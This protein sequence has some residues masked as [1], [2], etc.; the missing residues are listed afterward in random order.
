MPWLLAGAFEITGLR[1]G[2]VVGVGHFDL[3][4]CAGDG[5]GSGD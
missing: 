5:H 3:K 1:G 2:E 4:G